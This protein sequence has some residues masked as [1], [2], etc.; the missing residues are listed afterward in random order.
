MGSDWTA[1]AAL[2][3]AC[4]D[5]G[6]P[7]GAGN[8]QAELVIAPRLLAGIS[9]RPMSY[10]E[11]LRLHGTMPN[12]A[13]AAGGPRSWLLGEITQAGLRGRGGGGFALAAKLDAVRRARR[14]AV[15]VVN[16]CEGEPMSFKDRVLLQSL[17]HLVIDG[18]LC[19]SLVLEAGD[20][21]I[22]IEASSLEAHRSVERALEQRANGPSL[23]APLPRLATVPPGYVAGHEASIVSFLNGRQ[24]RPFAAPPRVSERGVDRRPTLVAN[25]ETLAY[26]ALIAR[27]GAGWYH[28]VGFGND[29]GTALVT[30]TGAVRHPGVYEI[31]YGQL[32]SSLLDDAG[33]LV[34]PGRAVL[35][36]GY[37][38]SWVEIGSALRLRLAPR[39]LRQMN[40]SLGAGVVVVL[41][42][43]AC[44]VAET[45]RVATWMAEQSAGQCGPCT[46]GLASISSAL[47]DLREGIATRRTMP[48]ILRWAKLVTGRGACVHPDGAARFVVSALR[49]FADEFE[50]HAR[51]G[52][53]E[54]CARQPVLLTPG[55]R[56]GTG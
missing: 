35:L 31:E 13:G 26:V 38:G 3:F 8:A 16:G 10:Q 46:N 44:P 24:A 20:V 53:C 41:P 5:T 21:V 40:A 32:L 55:S 42:Q 25:A 22:A 56:L 47:A 30:V 49:V 45:S 4:R 17:P 18:A 1:G 51:L 23:P 29:P 2:G 36:G 50:D 15:V 11:H 54:A 28:Q 37:S 14:P 12:R 43:N 19:C 52:P 33:G 9:D 6:L 27:Y 34:T 7:S 39:L 48:D